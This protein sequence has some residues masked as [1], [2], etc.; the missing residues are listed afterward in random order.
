MNEE[1]IRQYRR[2]VVIAGLLHDIGHC[3]LGHSYPTYVKNCTKKEPIEHET[4]GILIF[5]RLLEREDISRV[6]HSRKLDAEASAKDGCHLSFIDYICMMIAGKKKLLPKEMEGKWDAIPNDKKW[7]LQIVSNERNGIDMDRVDYLLRD[8]KYTG[9]KE[10]VNYERILR[11]ARICNYNGESIIC[12]K[13]DAMNDLIGLFQSRRTFYNYACNHRDNQIAEYMIL[14]ALQKAEENGFGFQVSRPSR[15][16]VND[17]VILAQAFEIMKNSMNPEDWKSIEALNRE[18]KTN[19]LLSNGCVPLSSAWKCLDV[20]LQA[21]DGFIE[22]LKEST[23]E[24]FYEA[25]QLLHRVDEGLFYTC[26]GEIVLNSPRIVKSPTGGK[27]RVN[28]HYHY[29]RERTVKYVTDEV[30]KLI[31]EKNW[32]I[33]TGDVIIDCALVSNG[34]GENNPFD[35]ILF[36]DDANTVGLYDE[37]SMSNGIS[38]VHQDVVVR[39]YSRTREHDGYWKDVFTMWRMEKHPNKGA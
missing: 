17:H 4:M 22:Q 39:F 37:Y 5:Q 38:P 19:G 8:S 25:R 14:N 11:K 1:E 34:Q 13:K 9:I 28:G 3:V 18:Y 35:F 30:N 36:C 26:V 6:V 21:T 15:L 27:K 32:P 10:S 16:V 12:F 24:E 20:Y 23:E 2:C 29:D 33:G 31:K 7:L